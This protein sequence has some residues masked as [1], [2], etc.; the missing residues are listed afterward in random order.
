MLYG[1]NDFICRMIIDAELP[2]YKV[3]FF[4]CV[5][6]HELKKVVCA[7]ENVL[8]IKHENAKYMKVF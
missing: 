3:S 8:D 4:R 7:F 2:A 5:S 6:S 1:T